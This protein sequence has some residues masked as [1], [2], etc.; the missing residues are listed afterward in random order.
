M[1][2]MELVEFARSMIKQASVKDLTLPAIT[3]GTLVGILLAKTRI[4][5]KRY[6]IKMTDRSPQLVQDPS[7]VL[8]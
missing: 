5:K 2:F 6:P 3:A 1:D 7:K 8:Y 4:R